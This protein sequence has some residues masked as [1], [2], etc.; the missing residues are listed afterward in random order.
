MLVM[1]YFQE[2]CFS[3]CKG[4]HAAIHRLVTFSLPCRQFWYRKGSLFQAQCNYQ[5]YNAWLVE[6]GLLS[7]Q[8]T[9]ENNMS[10]NTYVG[11]KHVVL[12]EISYIY[13]FHFKVLGMSLSNY[14]VCK[15]AFKVFP[16]FQAIHCNYT[17]GQCRLLLLDCLWILVTPVS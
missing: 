6:F 14:I 12:P 10:H 2:K 5:S 11:H 17:W 4:A 13:N 16:C 1:W 3:E 15:N 9:Q 7:N 8:S